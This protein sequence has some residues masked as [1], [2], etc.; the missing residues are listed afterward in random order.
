MIRL[1][2][3]SLGIASDRIWDAPEIRETYLQGEVFGH[4]RVEDGKRVVTSAIT[5]AGGLYVETRNNRYLLGTPD[6]AYLKFL[7][8]NGYEYFPDNPIVSIN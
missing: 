1:E 2:N 8:D 6:P 5:L 3:W 4:P 7:E